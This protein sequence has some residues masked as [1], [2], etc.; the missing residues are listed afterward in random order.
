M[1]RGE[2]EYEMP[3]AV[4]APRGGTPIAVPVL[5]GGTFMAFARG[6][7]AGNGVAARNWTPEQAALFEF[8]LCRLLSGDRKAQDVYFRKLH[9]L[10]ASSSARVVRGGAD[11]G[12]AGGMPGHG[13]G[14]STERQAQRADGARSHESP[15]GQLPLVCR[16]HENADPAASGQLYHTIVAARPGLCTRTNGIDRANLR[17][18]EFARLVHQ[19]GRLETEA[20][21]V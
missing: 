3:I 17:E 19:I 21:A 4:L 18:V 1:R 7:A 16:I 2:R 14:R 10:R 20:G 13:V 12:S 8:E 11:G 5:A 9:V 15:G 6:V